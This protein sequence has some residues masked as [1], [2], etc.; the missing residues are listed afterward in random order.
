MDDKS[1]VDSDRPASRSPY[2]II[3]ALKVFSACIL[4]YL[5]LVWHSGS[6]NSPSRLPQ[7]SGARKVLSENPLIDGHN[8][9]LILIRSIW[10]NHIYSKN[11]T[12]PFENGKMPGHFDLPRAV[13]G[14]MGGTF[15]SAW[16]CRFEC[17]LM[18][19][20]NI[21]SVLTK[22]K[23]PMPSGWLRFLRRGLCTIRQS[24]IRAIRSVQST[25]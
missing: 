13:A 20:S 1:D 15:W 9:F 14:Q 16:V 22:T 19:L 3:D 23:G 5:G 12:D 10:D 21:E 2:R 8:D 25:I 18:K 17:A 4:L 24:D 11:F 7:P 6:L